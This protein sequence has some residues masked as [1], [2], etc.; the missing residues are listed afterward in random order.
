MF[1]LFGMAWLLFSFVFGWR[2]FGLGR[3]VVFLVCSEVLCFGRFVFV[4]VS[5][6][7]TGFMCVWFSF[8]L[9]VCCC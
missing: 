4:F 1:F 6:C 9:C 3:C 2:L 5:F 7:L 8:D